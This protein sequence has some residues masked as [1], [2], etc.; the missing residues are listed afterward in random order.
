[1]GMIEEINQRKAVAQ[2][3]AMW[4]A[5]Q[6]AQ[7]QQVLANQARQL[8]QAEALGLAA[9]MANQAGR[10]NVDMAMNYQP[11]EVQWAPQAQQENYMT[12]NYV[13]PTNAYL[14]STAGNMPLPVNADQMPSNLIRA[15]GRK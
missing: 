10:S 5:A 6:K 9:L 8:G 4:D 1:M 3:A 13:D 2:K 15:R 14:N 12:E 11:R 7:E